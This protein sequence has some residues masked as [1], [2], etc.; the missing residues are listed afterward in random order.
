M[1]QSVTDAERE[2]GIRAIMRDRGYGRKD[3]EWTYDDERGAQMSDRVS[4]GTVEDLVA[5]YGVDAAQELLQDAAERER[6]GLPLL[7][8]PVPQ[9]V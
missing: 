6:F 5:A 8:K 9:P 3:A 7:V 1:L 2:Q 4:V